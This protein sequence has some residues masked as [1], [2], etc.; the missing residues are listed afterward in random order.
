MKEYC[1]RFNIFS[2]G[3]TVTLDEFTSIPMWFDEYERSYDLESNTF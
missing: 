3:G 1:E 2:E